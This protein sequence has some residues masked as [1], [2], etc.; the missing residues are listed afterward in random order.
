MT[1]PVKAVGS[2]RN[3]RSGAHFRESATRDAVMVQFRLKC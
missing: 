1:P 3:N 2:V